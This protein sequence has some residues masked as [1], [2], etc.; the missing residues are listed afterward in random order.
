[1]SAVPMRRLI[2]AASARRESGSFAVFAV[3]AVA[4]RTAA[5]ALVP[6]PST[7]A[8][9]VAAPNA[10]KL[11]RLMGSP[12]KRR[13]PLPPKSFD[14][15]LEVSDDR[16]VGRRALRVNR[17]GAQSARGD[18]CV[19][20]KWE[21]RFSIAFRKFRYSSLMRRDGQKGA[22]GVRRGAGIRPRTPDTGY[23]CRG[24]GAAGT[25]QS[26]RLRTRVNVSN[27]V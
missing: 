19:Q 4:E 6:V 15:V 5:V 2:F 20:V 27:S 16:K 24:A 18:G 7:A 23:S 22:A 25:A 14:I 1:M 9:L 10:R 3:F 17:N 21:I 11:R 12:P 13:D 26:A 8:A